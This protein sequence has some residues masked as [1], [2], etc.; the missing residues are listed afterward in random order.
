LDP[1]LKPYPGFAA[2]DCAPVYGPPDQIWHTVAW[3]GKTDLRALWNQPVRIRFTLHEASLY[4][5][6]FVQA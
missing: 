4:A 1:H 3:Q 6:Q 2:E 5:F